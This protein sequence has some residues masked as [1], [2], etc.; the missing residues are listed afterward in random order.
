M[1][2]ILLLSI[3]LTYPF[4]PHT[5]QYFA[6]YFV[7]IYTSLAVLLLPCRMSGQCPNLSRGPKTSFSGHGREIPAVSKTLPVLL[8]CTTISW[9]T[10]SQPLEMFMDPY[11]YVTLTLDLPLLL[12]HSQTAVFWGRR[13]KEWEAALADPTSSPWEARVEGVAPL[14]LVFTSLYFLCPVLGNIPALSDAIYCLLI[15]KFLRSNLENYPTVE[16]WVLSLCRIRVTSAQ[17]FLCTA[18]GKVEEKCNNDKSMIS[19]WRMHIIYIH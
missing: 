12:S 18:A 14:Q 16:T 3:S 6:K 8:A 10:Q 9:V 5:P 19:T 11:S 13:W 17:S 2:F 4:E 7:V 15:Y 1:F